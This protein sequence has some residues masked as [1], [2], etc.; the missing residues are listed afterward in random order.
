M[1]LRRPV[2]SDLHQS[3]IQ[4]V[5][6]E[7]TTPIRVRVRIGGVNPDGSRM[8][9]LVLTNLTIGTL[10]IHIPNNPIGNPNG[11]INVGNVG[12]DGVG[13]LVNSTFAQTALPDTRAPITE[14]QVRLLVPLQ[15][16]VVSQSFSAAQLA[17]SGISPGVPVTGYYRNSTSGVINQRT[18]QSL[19]GDM[20]LWVGAV[21][22]DSEFVPVTFVPAPTLIQA[23][24]GG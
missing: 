8:I 12:G 5:A 4:R 19:F 23:S 17:S 1:A 22:S 16:C 14:D 9:S 10:P 3:L 15:S 7:R 21:A 2:D 6:S 24:A 11:I 18:A 20:G 13:I